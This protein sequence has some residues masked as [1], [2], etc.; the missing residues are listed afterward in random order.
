MVVPV[1]SLQD[2][3]S[4]LASALKPAQRRAFMEAL[5]TRTLQEAASVPGL[6]RTLVVSPCK[7]ALGFAS[8]IGACTLEEQPPGG[9]NV[10]LGQA[11][12]ALKALG[13]T[14]MMIVSSDLPLLRGQDLAALAA[15]CDA[16]TI[17]IAPDQTR[18]GTNALCLDVA[19][20]LTF[21]FGP[22][23]FKRHL[24][25]IVELGRMHAVVDRMGLGFD[26]DSPHHL[27]QLRAID[28]AGIPAA[29]SSAVG[30]E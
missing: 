11:R 26:V 8:A 25:G 24:A 10:A 1:R 29:I 3:K 19:R 2:G 9:L 6:E 4:R 27:Q 21:L 20:E 12:I 16:N 22:D 5:L 15:A 17:A 23:S 13:A 18:E 14:R 28:D 30:M 7:Q